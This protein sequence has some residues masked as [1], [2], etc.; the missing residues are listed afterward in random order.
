M[1]IFTK[2]LFLLSAGVFV[3][4]Q[5]FTMTL[6]CETYDAT[7]GSMRMEISTTSVKMYVAP[8]PSGKVVGPASTTGALNT[9]VDPL[10]DGTACTLGSMCTN[11]ACVNLKCSAP[12]TT[13]SCLNDLDAADGYYC[14]KSVITAQIPVGGACTGAYA[15]Q[16]Y[17]GACNT[18]TLKCDSF[19]NAVKSQSLNSL[20]GG[21][22]TGF[23]TCTT[24]TVNA[25][26]TYNTASG[27]KTAGDLGYSC[28]AT[29]MAPTVS[30]YCQMV[31]GESIWL[32]AAQTVI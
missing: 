3:L 26:C 24:A 18:Q 31:G 29:S 27:V 2:L 21:D 28:V 14:Y 25:D 6:E 15:L 7:K 4:G 32:T 11:K 22:S 23:K 20:V 13:G 9:C 1:K 8:C 17:H 10:A 12:A 5:S 16:C 19:A 30:Y